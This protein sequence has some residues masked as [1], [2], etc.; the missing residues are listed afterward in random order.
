[1][2]ERYL[3]QIKLSQIGLRGQQKLQQAKVICVGA[4]G[5]GASCLEYLVAAG[6]GYIGICDGDIVSLSNLQ[7]QI[8]YREMDIGQL[9]STTAI[10]HLQQKNSE[11]IFQ[12][13]PFYITCESALVLLSSYDYVIDAT[14]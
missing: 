6:V 12:D 10:K 5:L 4:G 2:F 9:K 3:P 14:D 1:M 8:L 11:I 13:I 7:R